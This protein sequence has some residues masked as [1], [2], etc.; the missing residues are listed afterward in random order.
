LKREK[1]R[2]FKATQLTEYFVYDLRKRLDE[3]G[4]KRAVNW[5]EENEDKIIKRAKILHADYINHHAPRIHPEKVEERF[6]RQLKLEGE[7]RLIIVYGTIDLTEKPIVWDYKAVAKAKSQAEADSSV[8]LSLYSFA[9]NKNEVGFISF[10]KKGNPEV[11]PVTARRTAS[12]KL[13]ALRVIV[14]VAKSIQGGA[15]PLADPMSWKCS[16]RFCGFW[17][18]CRGKYQ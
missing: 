15:F 2:D 12:Q 11:V 14:S 8:Q 10:V 18:R 6:E 1:G 5:Q 16:E 3:E 9:A 7:K 13:W 17:K 4:G